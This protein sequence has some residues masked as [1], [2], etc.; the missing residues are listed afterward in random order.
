M[1][2]G[3]ARGEGGEGS[4]YGGSVADQRTRQRNQPARW[5]RPPSLQPPWSLVTRTR[6]LTLLIDTTSASL[7]SRHLEPGIPPQPPWSLV[8]WS[9]ELTFPI[10]TTSLQPPW[11]LVTRSR[12]LTLPIDAAFIMASLVSRHS[13]RELTLL[14]DTTFTIASLVSRHSE[15]GA[16]IADRYHYHYSL[17]GLSSLGPG[18]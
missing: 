8:T 7:V 3:S 4:S 16:N 11:S 15:P 18:S 2:L 6:E 1:Y 9:R 10:D 12:E 17:L 13:V 14:I 5:T